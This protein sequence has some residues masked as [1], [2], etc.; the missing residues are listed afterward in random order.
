MHDSRAAPRLLAVAHGTAS[1]DGLATTAGL[2]DAVRAARP[3][4]PVALCFLDV[5]SPRLPDVLARD[6]SPTVVV[7]VLLS[8]GFHVQN[9]IPAAVAGRP[10][11]VVARHLGPHPLLVDAL[12]DRLPAGPAAATVLVGAG[13]T[14][15]GARAELDATAALLGERLGVPVDVL[16]MA[17][18]LRDELRRRPT[19]VRVATYLLAQGRFTE[20]LQ[21]AC[22]DV[23]GATV[24]TVPTVPAAPIGVHP[25]LVE[26]VWTRYDEA[27]SRGPLDSPGT[28]R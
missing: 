28:A 15:D 7:P 18:D 22:A 24:P 4:V 25:A 26:L 19:P 8:T 14:R 17:D 12:V 2:V 5:A 23:P 9:D 13:S 27:V 3:D 10:D 21:A 6:V 11:T 1:P 16:T 20:T